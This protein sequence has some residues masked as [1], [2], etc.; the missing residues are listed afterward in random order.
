MNKCDK[1]GL[2]IKRFDIE[3]IGLIVEKPLEMAKWYHDVMGFNIKF[4]AKDDEKSVA[5]VTDPV[6]RVML[7]LAQI[8][9]VKALTT[10]TDHHLQLHIAAKSN[11]ID[12][13]IEYL[14]DKGA[15]LIEKCPL[16]R[17]GDYMVVLY[18]P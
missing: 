8:P 13:D 3:H 11:D 7:E 4:K 10:R 18:D 14:V 9:D 12:E 2:A 6:D 5:F 15:T 1:G 17:P 16:S